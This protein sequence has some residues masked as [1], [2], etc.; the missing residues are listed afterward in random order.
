MKQLILLVFVALFFIPT[1]GQIKNNQ[2]REHIIT[3]IPFK[4]ERKVNVFLPERYFR[5]STSTF[6]VTY[7]LDAHD[8]QVWNMTKSNIDYMVSRYTVIPTIVVG[9]VSEDRG[10]EFSPKNTTLQEHIA[11]EVFPLIE[12]HYR[13][14][15]FKV[16]IG[17]SWGGAFVSNTLFSE[18]MNMF[19]AYIGISPSLDAIDGRIYD[20][21]IKT[22]QEN[23]SLKKYFYYSS[24]D[25]GFEKGYVQEVTKMDSILLKYPKDD[26]K[27]KNRRFEGKDH[28]SAL[29]P[30]IND[31]L[32][33]MSRNY[34]TDQHTIETFAK[35]KNK[36]IQEQMDMFYKETH[37]K[38]GFTF[39]PTAKYL[40][41]VADDFRENKDL[42][43]AIETYLIG[44]KQDKN[45]HELFLGLADTYD[46][47]GDTIGAKETFTAALSV[48]EKNKEKVSERYYYNVVK[49]ANERL[50]SFKN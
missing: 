3:S 4:G 9:I 36:S 6:I 42:D 11:Q 10:S 33:S 26:F 28:F 27:W 12:K 8:E 32:T 20:N 45:S 48:L 7:M 5:D 18:K 21:A 14:K 49:W 44:L 19:D 37:D 25:V 40:K 47:K 39:K 38:F 1:S 50:D 43:A 34:F 16:I 41:F 24:G 31:G 2:N 23:K 22:L 13:V 35:N 15:P 17:H 46:K 30:A 29:I